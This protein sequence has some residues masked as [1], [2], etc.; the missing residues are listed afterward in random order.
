MRQILLSFFLLAAAMVASAQSAS[1][2]IPLPN[3]VECT[4][5]KAFVLNGATRIVADEQL[6]GEAQFL[7]DRIEEQLGLPITCTG[8]GKCRGAIVLAIDPS[9]DDNDEHYMLDI[10]R[11]GIRL[12]GSTPQAVF[13][14]I[15]TLTQW[16][17][18][19]ATTEERCTTVE[20][21]RIDDSPRYGYWA[22]MLDP[23]RHFLP[24][25]DVKRFIDEMVRYK[26]NVLQLHL[27]DDQGWRV[28][29]DSHPELTAAGPH[30]TK[31]ELKELIRYAASRHVEMVPELDIP[32]HTYGLLRSHRELLCQCVD[33][34]GWGAGLRTDVM[35]CA[36]CDGVYPLLT[37]ILGEVCDL[38]PSPYIHLGGDESLIEKNWGHCEACQALRQRLGLQGNDE[39][40]GYFFSHLW[41]LLHEAGKKPILW[42]EMDNI[43]PPA[44]RYLFDYPDDVTL[45]TWRNGLTPKAI[46][47]TATHGNQLLMAP[48]EHC[49]FD[50]PQA[51]NDLPETNNWGMPIL[52]LRKA[53]DWEV[54]YP[55][56]NV[57]KSHIQGVM[58]TLWGEAINDI[59]RAFYMTYP[60]A[61]ALAE[62][63][64]TN[65][66]YR[67]W[68]EFLDRLK[69]VLADML[70]RG[71]PYRV[72]W[73][74]Y[75]RHGGN[76]RIIK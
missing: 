52:P 33:T 43:W 39:L 69:P 14:G 15:Q 46:E 62:A 4:S 71:L 3:S 50:Y 67:R 47:L 68:E 13:D 44:T 38:F 60:R 19:H 58:G 41:P 7:A 26:F 20:A 12:A 32:G 31:A 61:M 24:V 16:L 53:Y 6:A 55:E 11:K 22:L 34:T 21:V 17:L 51:R 63:G 54:D 1:A 9:L 73:E 57:G 76:D 74:C 56:V 8:D 48:G 65:Q 72:P 42:I 28:P 35:L 40:M 49:Y 27:T 36:A 37:D 64:W 23:A 10:T 66:E 5:D 45:V 30:Y 75:G 59:N 29:I 25:N 2:L 18:T 70:S